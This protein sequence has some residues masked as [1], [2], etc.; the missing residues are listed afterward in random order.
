MPDV[1]MIYIIIS[2]M[3]VMLP[4]FVII[5]VFWSVYGTRFLYFNTDRTARLVRIRKLNKDSSVKIDGKKFSLKDAKP[6]IYK[7][8]IGVSPMYII[9]HDSPFPL[10][11]S[12]SKLD[13]PTTTP[14]ELQEL[15]KLGEMKAM[16]SKPKKETGFIIILGM[17]GF[18]MGFLICFVF[19]AANIIVL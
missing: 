3:I 5:F 6:V 17:T 9:K 8:P 16:L 10:E 2:I 19:F 15:T 18:I 4:V 7:R 11:L 13:S 14:A 12:G 1:G